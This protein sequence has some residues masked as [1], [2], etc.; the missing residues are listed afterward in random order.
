MPKLSYLS[1]VIVDTIII[2]IVIF[3]ADMTVEKMYAKKHGYIISP[4]QVST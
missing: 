4:N 1:D 3:Y 2:A